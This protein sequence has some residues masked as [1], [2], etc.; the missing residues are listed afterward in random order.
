[1]KDPYETLGS[2][3]P[4]RPKN[5]EGVTGAWPRS[6]TRTSIPEIRVGGAIQEVAGAYDLLSD[7]EQASTI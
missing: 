2:H 4:P 3:A 5:S 1:V 7:P 6:C